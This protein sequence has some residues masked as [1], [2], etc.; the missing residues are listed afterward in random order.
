M[1]ECVYVLYASVSVCVGRFAHA[2]AVKSAYIL[3]INQLGLVPF[4]DLL[5]L[6]ETLHVFK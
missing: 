1:Y 4:L 6:G 2:R 3:V 5:A